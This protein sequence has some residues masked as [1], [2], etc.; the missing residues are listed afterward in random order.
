MKL[1]SQIQNR[2]VEYIKQKKIHLYAGKDTADVNT[3]R[4]KTKG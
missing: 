2:M 1:N 4:L 3:Q